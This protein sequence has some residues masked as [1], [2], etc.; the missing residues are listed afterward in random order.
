[1][2][3]CYAFSRC[4]F[5]W[6]PSHNL[7]VEDLLTQL[8]WRYTPMMRWIIQCWRTPRQNLTVRIFVTVG[9]TAAPPSVHSV[10]KLQS[11]RVSVLIQM[12][13]QI[14]RQCPHS[15]RRIIQCYYL[16]SSSSALIR[17][18]LEFDRRIIR[19]C[20]LRLACCAVYQLHRRY[21]PMVPLVHPTV[22]ISFVFFRG[23]DPWKIDYLLNL[24][25]G[26][27]ASLGP[28]NVYKD[29]LNNMVSPIDHVSW[30]TKIKLKL[31]S[32]GAM[33]TTTNSLFQSRKLQ[34]SIKLN[35]MQH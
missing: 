19:Q 20:Q 23:F 2:N 11:W 29:M 30:I 6:C 34:W 13:R 26:I 28:R 33:F 24:A 1:M 10:L 21:T 27:L 5:I 7:A 8:L 16:R 22:S 31:M 15:D 17:H 9:W 3:Q 14:D 25:C 18:I 4:W 32:Y 35:T 12:K